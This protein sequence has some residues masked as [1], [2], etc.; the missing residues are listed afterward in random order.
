MNVR[1]RIAIAAILAGAIL[2][3]TAC[4]TASYRCSGNDCDVSLGGEGS[5]TTL[6]ED[7]ST[8]TL[9]SAGGGRATFTVDGS[10]LSCATGETVNVGSTEI[11]CEKIGDSKLELHFQL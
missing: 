11:T 6:G 8:V 9:I 10:R 3:L 1:K 2:G 5:H 4:N 7:G